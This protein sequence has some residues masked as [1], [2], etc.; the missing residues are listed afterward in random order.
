MKDVRGLPQAAIHSEKVAP[1]AKAILR[2]ASRQSAALDTLSPGARA[3]AVA[4][5]SLDTLLDDPAVDIVA[6]CSPHEFHAEQVVA[7]CGA[8]KKA[9]FCEKPL[10]VTRDEAERIA[11]ASARYG[12][13]VVVGTMNLWDPAAGL[14]TDRSSF[15]VSAIVPSAPKGL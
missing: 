11:E 5:T 9:V 13:P 2:S 12:V 6:V 7:A 8:G 4:S 14:R 3:G 10:A 1:S 15:T